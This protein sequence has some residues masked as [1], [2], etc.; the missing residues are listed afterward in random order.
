M[1]R[2]LVHTTA[3]VP[4]AE[5]YPPSH[6][7]LP[8]H[9]LRHVSYHELWLSEVDLINEVPGIIERAFQIAKS[10]NVADLGELRAQLAGEGYVNAATTLAGRSLSQQLV[11]MVGEARQR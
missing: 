10:G 11:R 3:Q 8:S 1:R 2:Q 9:V 4:G 7:W 6:S 5:I